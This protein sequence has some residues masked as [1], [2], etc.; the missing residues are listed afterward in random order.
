MPETRSSFLVDERGHQLRGVHRARSH[1]HELPAA[2]GEIRFHQLFGVVDG[3]HGG[4]A[5]RSQVRAHQ[6]RL[7]IGVAYASDAG[8]SVEVRQIVFEARAE[9]GV[10]DGVDLALKAP[11]AVAK[12]H[13]RAPCSQMGVVVHA[14]EHVQHY[15]AVG[16]SSEES[17]HGA[18]FVSPI[19]RL[20]RESISIR[21]RNP[22]R[23]HLGC[24]SRFSAR[25]AG[26]WRRAA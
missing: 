17:A 13:A 19:A 21:L 23:G 11:V 5:E 2:V 15:I 10:L 8:A 16:C 20:R 26:D 1:G 9:R 12:D 14:E 18:P 7:G 3:A 24:D 25:A 22:R 4:Q 6:K